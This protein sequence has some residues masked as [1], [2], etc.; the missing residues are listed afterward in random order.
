ML[1][2]SSHFIGQGLRWPFST[3]STPILRADVALIKTRVLDST[4]F[5]K[6]LLMLHCGFPSGI[7]RLT[8]TPYRNKLRRRFYHSARGLPTSRSSVSAGKF[9]RIHALAIVGGSGGSDRRLG[10]GKDHE[11]LGIR[12]A[13]GYC[14]GDCWRREGRGRACPGRPGQAEVRLAFRGQEPCPHSVRRSTSTHGC[15]RRIRATE[16]FRFHPDE[17]S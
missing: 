12:A 2:L 17:T 16:I 1:K 7:S 5:A 6:R 10:H 14:S 3:Y 11:R 15:S 4:N 9:R 13:H 8:V